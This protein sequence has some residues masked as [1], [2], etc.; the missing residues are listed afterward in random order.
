MNT[1]ILVEET[2]GRELGIR[3]DQLDS[4]MALDLKLLKWFSLNCPRAS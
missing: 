1:G 3:S 2:T 4:L